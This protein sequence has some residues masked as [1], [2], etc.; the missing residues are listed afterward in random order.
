MNKNLWKGSWDQIKGSLKKKYARLTN[1]DL[2]YT[3]GQEEE[4][5][6]RIQMRLGFSRELVDFL[7]QEHFEHLKKKSGKPAD[8]K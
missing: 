6:G 3:E 2:A 5:Y 8:K 1:D 4:L 7:I